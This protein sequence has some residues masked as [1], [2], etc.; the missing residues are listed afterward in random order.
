MQRNDFKALSKA[1]LIDSI[2][3]PDPSDDA[4]QTMQ[5]MAAELA[6]LRTEISVLKDTLTSP[7]SAINIKVSD[8]QS[9]LNKQA[10]IISKQQRF[11]EDI[12]RKERECNLVLFGVPDDNE[13]MDGAT[14]DEAKVRKVWEAAG[15]TSNVRSVR[16]LGRRDIGS[17]NRQGGRPRILLVTVESRQ[18][19]DAVLE[20]AKQLKEGTDTYKKIYI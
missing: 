17:D 2:L 16:R 6:A 20:R 14:T 4:V 9:Q 11:L 19:R 8:L 15:A 1:D 18:D 7:E 12:D 3:A 10:E 5:T 13:S